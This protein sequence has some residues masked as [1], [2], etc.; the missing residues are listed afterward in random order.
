MKGF[1]EK[2]RRYKGSVIIKNLTTGEIKVVENIVTSGFYNIVASAMAGGSIDLISH[3]AI[4]DDS[5][6]AQVTDTALYNELYRKDI[7][8]KSYSGNKIIITAIIAGGDAN[9]VWREIGLF[10]AASSGS[11]TNRLVINYTHSAGDVV[12]I[13]WNIQPE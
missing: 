4:G 1:N 2:V 5:T 3:I 9:F 10:N 6:I 11:M 7:I 13:T 8:T 12:S